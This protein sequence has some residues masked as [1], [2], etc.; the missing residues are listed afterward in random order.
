MTIPIAACH[1]P[2]SVV[3]IDDNRKY[4]STL[5]IKLDIRQFSPKFFFNSSEALSFLQSYEPNPF[6]KRC[7]SRP[8]ESHF[9][10]RNLEI[11]VRKIREELYNPA[12]FDEISVVVVDYAMPGLNGLEL[13]Q[14]LKERR[15]Y[16]IILLTGEAD[17][18][19]AVA[20]FNEGI[21]DKFLRKDLYDFH[22]VLNQTILNLQQDYFTNLSQL[23][24]DSLTKDHEHPIINWLDE[25]AFLELFDKI[26]QDHDF[27]E[28]YI[29]D[30]FG[31][32]MFLSYSG[33]PAWLVV[34]SEDEMVAAFEVAD[35]SDTAFPKAMLE[36]MR[37]KRKVLYMHE[38]GLCDDP[39]EAAQS[40]HPAKVLAGRKTRYY[41]AFIDDPLAYDIQPAKILSYEAYRQKKTLL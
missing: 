23:I 5:N 9:D 24:L 15:S 21:I 10:H 11:D 3:F 18:S 38:G 14:Q 20:A 26:Y 12:R 31:S 17:E 28:Y 36:A 7:M 34:K 30:A 33:K 32:F 19:K 1:H 29:T 35:N 25:P 13:C 27:T 6:T 4:L 39:L 41:Y 2:T 40:L 22:N 37:D 16:K 8:E